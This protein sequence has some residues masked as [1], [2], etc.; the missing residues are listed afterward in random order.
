[1]SD[2][3]VYIVD[4]VTVK[5]G[6]GAR[7]PRRLHEKLRS[8]RAGTRHDFAAYLGG[9]P[10]WLEERVQHDLLRLDGKGREPGLGLFGGYR[11]NL[12]GGSW[13]WKEAAQI[14]ASRERLFLSNPSDIASLTNV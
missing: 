7:L 12:N 3:T 9:A 11:S 13:W 5:P 6:S 4:Q 2:E 8:R 10:V 14:I 1:M